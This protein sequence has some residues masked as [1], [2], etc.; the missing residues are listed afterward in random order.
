[1]DVI[2]LNVGKSACT[3]FLANVFLALLHADKN[4]NVD[5]RVWTRHSLTTCSRATN[6][7]KGIFQK[8]SEMSHL[9][10]F[11]KK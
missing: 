8:G 9:D 4:M 11:L 5:S 1:M 3:D 7:C 6:L 10:F 2:L